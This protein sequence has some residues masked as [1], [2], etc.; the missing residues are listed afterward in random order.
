MIYST[1]RTVKKKEEDS[2][3]KTLFY[4]HRSEKYSTGKFIRDIIYRPK[5]REKKE[6]E[7]YGRL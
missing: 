6:K 7:E 3:R 4:S 5:K 2:K 1:I